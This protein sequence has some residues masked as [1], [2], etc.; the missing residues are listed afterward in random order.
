MPHV[1]AVQ[2]DAAHARADSK[3]RQGAEREVR[4][5]DVEALPAVPARQLEE[6]PAKRGCARRELLQ[7]DLQALDRT[8]RRDLIAHESP[9]LGVGGVR[10]HVGDHERA[11]QRGP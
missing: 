11:H 6:A 10:P 5:D 7:L 1:G 2:R 9:A 8:Q 3:R 4:V